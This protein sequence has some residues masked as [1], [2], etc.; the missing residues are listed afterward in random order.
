M[1]DR[2]PLTSARSSSR[3]T[4]T[5]QTYCVIDYPIHLDDTDVYWEV[6]E[7]GSRFAFD[8]TTRVVTVYH[9]EDPENP[10]TRPYD[11]AENERADAR[12]SEATVKE[13]QIDYLRAIGLNAAPDELAALQAATL[14]AE[15]IE[16]GDPWR[17]PTGAHDAYP[18]GAIVSHSGKIW[19]STVAANVWEPGVSGWVES[20]VACPD[21]IQP[22]GAHDAYNI[23]DCVSFES[24]CYLSL[25]D[26]NVWSPTALPTGWEETECL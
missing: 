14:A 26:A 10:T 22:T 16:E 8:D 12:S 19:E 24:L 21:W 11:D 13:A 17:Q 25:I 7:D 3:T 6:L 1:D 5:G 18:L 15:G 9:F 20:G 23:G 4:A 2:C